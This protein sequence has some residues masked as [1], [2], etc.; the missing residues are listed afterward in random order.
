MGRAPSSRQTERNMGLALLCDRD[1]H[2][3]TAVE[4]VTRSQFQCFLRR[5]DDEVTTSIFFRDLE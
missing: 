3:F 5:L 1:P 2:F 4:H